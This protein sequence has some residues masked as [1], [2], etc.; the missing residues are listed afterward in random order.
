MLRPPPPPPP[1]SERGGGG[2]TGGGKGTRGLRGPRVDVEEFRGDGESKGP[3][4]E[5]P[6]PFEV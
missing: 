3:V 5:R 1:Q 4:R 2:R 6:D